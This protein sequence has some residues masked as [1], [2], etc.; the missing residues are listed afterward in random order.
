MSF[1]YCYAFNIAIWNTNITNSYDIQH[2]STSSIAAALARSKSTP[3]L[4][5]SVAIIPLETMPINRHNT[6]PPGLTVMS[7]SGPGSHC[8]FHT[9]MDDLASM[10]EQLSDSDESQERE[11]AMKQAA[12]ADIT[13][14]MT[15]SSITS[16]VTDASAQKSPLATDAPPGALS[17]SP[18]SARPCTVSNMPAQVYQPAITIGSPSQSPFIPID[19]IGRNTAAYP[20]AHSPVPFGAG[21]ELS[22]R[23]YAH[24]PSGSQITQISPFNT[25]YISSHHGLPP[26]PLPPPPHSSGGGGL[27]PLAIPP[28]QPSSPG[29]LSA[30]SNHSPMSVSPSQYTSYSPGLNN[31]SSAGSLPVSEQSTEALLHEITRLRERLHMLETENSS[32]NLKLSQ[33]QWEVDNR[34]AEIE[35]HICGSEDESS[36]PSS[37]KDETCVSKESVI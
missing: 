15:V 5:E 3:G 36:V 28:Q 25:P 30:V 27:Q 10:D 24:P 9:R 1:I 21:M 20:P 4:V 14:S 11:Y 7:S 12:S 19:A 17:T 29:M 26:P 34:L 35:L 6:L 23:A 18:P 8:S 2:P 32:M 37:E 16:Y 33:K 22:G 31:A 13:H